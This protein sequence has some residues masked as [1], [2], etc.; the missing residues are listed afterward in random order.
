MK[1]QEMIEDSRPRERFLKYGKEA[2]S[3]AELFAILLRTGTQ[4]ENVI[5]MSNRL[6]G[7]FGL[8]KL[9]ECSLRE[10]Q[11]I[12]GIGPAKAMQ[13]LAIAEISKRQI[14]SLKPIKH[15]KSAEDVFNLF[16]ERLKDEKQECFYVL[17]LS[18]KNSII[19]EELIT[20]GILDSSIIHPREVFRP[21]IRNSC[22][23]IILVHNHPSGDPAPSQEDKEITKKLIETGKEI[24]INVLDHIIIGDG[25]WWSWK[26]EGK[27]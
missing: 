24:D 22:S 21:A 27:A 16:H 9:F 15:I 13:I 5:D 17:M 25:G 12:K 14:Q 8:D 23:K 18:S 11:E 2:L 10:L 7:E 26:E 1:I 19:K 4:D 3:N 20:R 6:I